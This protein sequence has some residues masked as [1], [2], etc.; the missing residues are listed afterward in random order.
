VSNGT[1]NISQVPVG[2]YNLMTFDRVNQIKRNDM[3]RTWAGAH[4]EAPRG[5]FGKKERDN[6]GDYS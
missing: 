1:T 3:N 2:K 4:K 6:T 5:F